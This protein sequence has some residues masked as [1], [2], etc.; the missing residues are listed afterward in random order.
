MH[1]DCDSMLGL[2]WCAE[3]VWVSVKG[4]PASRLAGL[5]AGFGDSCL[6]IAGQKHLI[7]SV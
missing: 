6:V 3:K 7:R 5:I 4:A 2:G 1:V